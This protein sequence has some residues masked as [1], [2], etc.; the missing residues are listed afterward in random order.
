MSFRPRLS[1]ILVTKNRANLL[2]RSLT[3]II[4]E[5]ET[6]YGDAEI[7]VI[8]G[9][10][11]DGTVEIIREHANKIA[12]WSSELDSG[13]GEAVNRGIAHARGDILRLIGDDDEF[14]P[15]RLH[16]MMQVVDQLPEYDVIA[17]HNDVYLETNGTQHHQSQRRFRGEVGRTQ[18]YRWGPEAILI[19]E[20][21]F[22]RK[23]ALVMHH[24][25][26]ES[27]RWWGF[28]DLF[29]RMINS[30]VRFF[31]LP[32]TILKTYQTAQSETYSNLS[33]PAF[34]EEFSRVIEKH[35][36]FRW[37]LWHQYGGSLRPGHIAHLYIAQFCKATGFHPRKMLR[38]MLNTWRRA[39][40]G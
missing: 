9:G 7:V 17:G 18:M 40:G 26:D 14:L 37:R 8:D 38:T 21:C 24:G 5:L 1:I 19:P 20:V 29:L 12:Y 32:I 30:G 3:S 11:H 36:G 4:S 16:L 34:H 15:Q 2:R 23:S 13:V 27:L 6:N 28:I 22:F 39:P 31:V 35:A 10:S 25:Y 33:N